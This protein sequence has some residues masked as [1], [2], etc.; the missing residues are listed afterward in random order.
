MEKNTKS[1]I[2]IREGVK[3]LT[4][5]YLTKNNLWDSEWLQEKY[6]HKFNTQITHK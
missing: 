3:Q 1:I 5:D 4:A 6:P 2:Q